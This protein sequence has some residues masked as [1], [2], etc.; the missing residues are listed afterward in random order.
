MKKI[1]SIIVA[2]ATL[3][4]LVSFVPYAR[5][6]TANFSYQP[7]NGFVPDASTAKIIAEAVWVPIYG[8]EE[9]NRKKPFKAVLTGNVWHVN[10]T[11]PT[12]FSG[13]VP[14]A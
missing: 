7:K 13:G 9:V 3:S 10:G 2:T 1:H 11:L 4:L 8:K 6:Q 12:S 14:Y 5:P